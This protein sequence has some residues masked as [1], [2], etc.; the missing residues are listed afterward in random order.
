[1]MCRCQCENVISNNT[2][3]R[4][5]YNAALNTLLSTIMYVLCSSMMRFEEKQLLHALRIVWCYCWHLL[6]LL[7]LWLLLIIWLHVFFLYNNYTLCVYI[8][9][10]K[11]IMNYYVNQNTSVNI[12]PKKLSNFLLK[13]TYSQNNTFFWENIHLIHYSYFTKINFFVSK[14]I[15]VLFKIVKYIC[16]NKTFVNLQL[17]S[18]HKK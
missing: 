8:F 11:T 9:T 5:W 15:K 18:T 16:K 14:Y 3:Y 12:L 4:M 10:M 7:L 1:M 13:K 6:L 2:S 17:F